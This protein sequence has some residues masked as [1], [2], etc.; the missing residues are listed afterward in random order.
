MMRTRYS[1]ILPLVLLVSAAVWAAAAADQR[2]GLAPLAAGGGY[3]VTFHVN[4]PSTV[5]DGAT[6]TCK[7]RIAPR[8]SAFERLTGKAVAAETL[9]GVATVAGSSA[10]CTVQL[11]LA[12][13]LTH[14]S[15]DAVLSYEIDAYTSAGPAFVRTQQG[16]ALT[17]ADPRTGAIANL[18]LNV[19]L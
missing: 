2:D 15:Q 13:A 9:P 17:I 5:P 14:P 11:P 8:L 4:A 18:L 7:A 12:F 10:N 3:A 1:R 19:N 6:V 16:I